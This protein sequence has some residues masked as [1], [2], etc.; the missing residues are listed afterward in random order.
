MDPET[1]E[2]TTVVVTPEPIVEETPVETEVRESQE[3]AIDLDHE[4]RL[5]RVEER[6]NTLEGTVAGFAQATAEAIESVSQDVAMAEASADLAIDVAVAAE[7]TANDAGELA[8]AA[9]NE[10]AT[11]S[12][13]DEESTEDDTIPSSA[14][15]HPIFRSWQEW[16]DGR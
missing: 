1:T 5:T 2:V 7:E 16:K 11:E 10:D 15:K 4:Q 9:V 14:R 12:V 8:E 13:A 6:L 3:I